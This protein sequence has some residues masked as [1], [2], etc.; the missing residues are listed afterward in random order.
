M[1]Q[2]DVSASRR[3]RS[4]HS[5]VIRDFC[6]LRWCWC[7]LLSAFSAVI[8]E[9]RLVF[10]KRCAHAAV[11]FGVNPP[12]HSI[13]HKEL[14]LFRQDTFLLVKNE[15]ATIPAG[16]TGLVQARIRLKTLSVS[17]A[18]SNDGDLKHMWIDWSSRPAFDFMGHACRVADKELFSVIFLQIQLPRLTSRTEWQKSIRKMFDCSFFSSTHF[19]SSP[20]GWGRRPKMGSCVRPG[21]SKKRDPAKKVGLFERKKEGFFGNPRSPLKFILYK[22]V[23]GGVGSRGH[24]LLCGQVTRDT[25]AQ[26]KWPKAMVILLLRPCS[27][28]LIVEDAAVSKESW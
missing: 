2:L 15:A 21:R 14:S 25:L 4:G 20:S 12:G 28:S 27:A 18:H 17:E 7:N 26:A 10:W 8:S 1:S 16:L 9:L 23:L 6:I 22:K 13:R 11:I 5:I 19:I 24:S 3:A